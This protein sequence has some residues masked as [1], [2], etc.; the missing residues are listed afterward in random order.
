M[1]FVHAG[2]GDRSLDH[3]AGEE[4]QARAHA[5]RV[6]GEIGDLTLVLEHRPV[7]TTGRRATW[8][9]PGQLVGYP[10]VRLD[11]PAEEF[12]ALVGEALVTVCAEFGVDATAGTEGVLVGE[13]RIATVGIRVA[14]GV[15]MRGFALNCDPNLAAFDQLP[16][17][18]ATSLTAETARP[19]TVRQVLP[20]LEGALADRLGA[21]ETFHRTLAQL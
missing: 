19:V 2:F 11:D 13:R 21:L 5:K 14:K 6:A 12:A 4:L 18:P 9:G 10:I 16:D 1:I 7:Y 17:R 15:T 8:H 20:V 3:A